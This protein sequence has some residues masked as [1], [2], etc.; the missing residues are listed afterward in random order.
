MQLVTLWSNTDFSEK[1]MHC[2]CKSET[3]FGDNI[4]HTPFRTVYHVF[5]A[6]LRNVIKYTERV[7]IDAQ[8]I[9]AVLKKEA[10]SVFEIPLGKSNRDLSR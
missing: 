7:Q 3:R 1:C 5:S 4:P 9:S 8:E 2:T 6:G 10:L